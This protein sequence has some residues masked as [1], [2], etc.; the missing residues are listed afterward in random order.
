MLGISRLDGT[1]D[2]ATARFSSCGLGNNQVCYRVEGVL[3]CE[4]DSSDLIF[5]FNTSGY[6]S[7]FKGDNGDEVF[8]R[9]VDHGGLPGG[10]IGGSSGSTPGPSEGGM[11]AIGKDNLGNAHVVFVDAYG[12]LYD[13]KKGVDRP[14]LELLAATSAVAVPF[15]SPPDTVVEFPDM[16]TNTGCTDLNV[17]LTAS[18]TSNGST[19]PAPG[20]SSINSRLD[21]S[22]SSMADMLS[23]NG[24]KISFVNDVKYV[25]DDQFGGSTDEVV[26]FAD[27]RQTYNQS[28]AAVPGFLNNTFSSRVGDVFDPPTPTLGTGIITAP[29]DTAGIRVHANGPLVNRGPNSFYCEFTA[30]ND[31]DYYLDV[32]TRR[33]EIRL[34]LVGGCLLDTTTLHYGAAAAS[35]RLATNVLYLG[36]G[37]WTPHGINVDALGTQ[38]IYQSFMSYGVSKH[39][40]ALMSRT[41][42]GHQDWISIQGDPNFC[43]ASC[44]PALTTGVALG[45]AS[46]DGVLYSAITGTVICRSFIDSV[47][48]HSVGANWVWSKPN[49]AFTNDSTMG[50]SGNGRTIGVVSAP[51]QAALLNRMTLDITTFKERNGVAVPGW[52]LTMYNDHDLGSRDTAYYD[53]A[54]SVG[55]STPTPTATS[56]IGRVVGMVKIPFGCGYAPLKNV[57]ACSQNRIAF[58][59]NWDTLWNQA[60]KPAGQHALSYTA[61]SA[62]T[63]EGVAFTFAEND[64]APNGEFTVGT[65]LFAW[66]VYPTPHAAGG[67]IAKLATLV[68]QWAGF[69]RGDVNNDG[70]INLAD[71]VYLAAHVNFGGPGAIPFRHLGDANASGGAPTAADIQVLV[72]YYFNYGPCPSGAFV[73]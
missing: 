31:P 27:S 68:N 17:N 33:P 18:T 49:A 42:T 51:A 26:T 10:F 29:G 1:V 43:D 30:H 28:A 60:T 69:G 2:Y 63:D 34:T 58:I 4:P 11:G 8:S 24:Q 37:T 48:D 71:V 12:G 52:K 40:Q 70:F 67:D 61:P 25:S 14:R 73:L 5:A 44:K 50:L 47:Q 39:R 56:G 46:T 35:T 19:T 13:M 59:P 54:H 45:E 38:F 72:D 3:T 21:E 16:Y 7:C 53:G 55:W 15:G 23:G 65:A 62:S 6:L 22:S 41:W 64:F 20:F 36:D 57:T 66:A 9:R 32:P